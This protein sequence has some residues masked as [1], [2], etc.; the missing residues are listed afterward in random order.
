MYNKIV[1]LYSFFLTF[2]FEMHVFFEN[3]LA[4][5]LHIL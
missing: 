5:I 4:S 2:F 3:I 1:C